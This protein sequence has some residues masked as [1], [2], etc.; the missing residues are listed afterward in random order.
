MPDITDDTRVEFANDSRSPGGVVSQITGIVSNLLPKLNWAK[1]HGH[2]RVLQS[3]TLIVQ[4][5]K[6]GTLDSTTKIP[7]TIVNQGQTGTSFA[8]AGLMADIRP[9]ITN[10][11]SDSIR[12]DTNFSVSSLINYGVGNFGG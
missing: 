1:S 2:A 8:D 9:I 7:Y 3:S 12:L 4:E 11:Q 5:G 6:K 10:P